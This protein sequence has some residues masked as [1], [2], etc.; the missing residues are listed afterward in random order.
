M[1][2][3]L[4]QKSCEK[5]CFVFINFTNIL[6][7]WKRIHRTFCCRAFTSITA[8]CNQFNLF[9][10]SNIWI[11]I[12][13]HS[14]LRDETTLS[15]KTGKTRENNATHLLEKGEKQKNPPLANGFGFF[16]GFFFFFFSSLP[17]ISS[18]PL[19][20]SVCNSQPG[21]APGARAS[22]PGLLP[23]TDRQ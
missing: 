3:R 21:P 20:N 23:C 14:A 2:P 5:S 22:Q 16:F 4:N 17:L 12:C 7:N 19:S 1:I 15:D 9:I 11:L 13:T 8:H 6:S 18:S 10:S